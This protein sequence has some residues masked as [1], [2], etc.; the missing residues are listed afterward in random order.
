MILLFIHVCACCWF[1]IVKSDKDWEP[2][3]GLSESIYDIES[4]GYQF[5]ISFYVSILALT[6][7]DIYPANLIQY[8]FACIILLSGAILQASI[9]GEFTD[10]M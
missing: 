8:F 4:I 5:W 6:G 1:F 7:N 10:I 2:G 9:F 3:Q